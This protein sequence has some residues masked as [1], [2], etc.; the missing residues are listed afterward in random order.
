M[1]MSGDIR[2]LIREVLSEELAAFRSRGTA[3]PAPQKHVETVTIASDADLAAFARRVLTLGRDGKTRGEIEAGRYEF[4]LGHE[5]GAPVA[6][7]RP[8]SGPAGT[9]VDFAGGLVTENEIRR[10]PGGVTCVRAGKS[11][12]FTPLAKDEM[13]R[14]GIRVERTSS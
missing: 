12:C 4:R 7:S 13:R 11:V 9:P 5:T 2:Q 10:L 3:A 1:K 14:Q 6:V 8:R